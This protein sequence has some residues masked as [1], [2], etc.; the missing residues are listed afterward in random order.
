M[1]NIILLRNPDINMSNYNNFCL[2]AFIILI[3]YLA[4]SNFN[5]NLD[6]RQNPDLIYNF[7]SSH[8]VKL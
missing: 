4:L 1:I 7:T 3:N 8:K 6:L 5:Q 2:K